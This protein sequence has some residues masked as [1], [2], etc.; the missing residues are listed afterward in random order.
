[1]RTD[2]SRLSRSRV[3]SAGAAAGRRLSAPHRLGAA[4]SFWGG[5]YSA[6]HDDDGGGGGID[7]VVA[8]PQTPS[9]HTGAFLYSL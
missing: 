9:R 6:A 2:R 7:H 8:L 4:A 5:K 3:L 1:M